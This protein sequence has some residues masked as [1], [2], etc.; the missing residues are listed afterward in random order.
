MKKKNRTAKVREIVLNLDYG[1]I[2]PVKV[3]NKLCPTLIDT[4]ATRSCISE[5]FYNTLGN[6]ELQEICG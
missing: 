3:H 2:I 4:G 1:A 6:T 5:H